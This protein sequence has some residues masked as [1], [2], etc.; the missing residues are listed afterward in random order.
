MS[1]PLTQEGLGLEMC[2][3]IDQAEITAVR[4]KA[5]LA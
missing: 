4:K 1:S 3:Y 2:N 5:G